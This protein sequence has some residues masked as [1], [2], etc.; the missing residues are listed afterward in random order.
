M[1]QLVNQTCALCS[2]RISSVLEGEF[3]AACGHP[4][5]RP[6]KRPGSS[7]GACPSCGADISD[8]AAMEKRLRQLTAAARER[9]RQHELRERRRSSADTVNR[10]VVIAA[11]V[12]SIG[13]LLTVAT[14][15]QALWGGGG[16]YVIA[17]GAIIGGGIRLV[18]ALRRGRDQE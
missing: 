18:W 15:A 9:Q 10:D 16:M 8:P 2:Q 12:F 17:Y 3:C 6:C 4:V 11:S 7:A 13:V 1:P 5:H 14:Y